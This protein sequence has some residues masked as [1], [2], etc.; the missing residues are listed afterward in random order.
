LARVLQAL[1]FEAS[2]LLSLRAEASGRSRPLKVG[3]LALP[4]GSQQMLP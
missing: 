2:A 3:F 4:R 1:G